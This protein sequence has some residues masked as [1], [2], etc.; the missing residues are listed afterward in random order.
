[1]ARGSGMRSAPESEARKRESSF[2]RSGVLIIE[3]GM[4]PLELDGRIFPRV[5]RAGSNW[6]SIEVQ[7]M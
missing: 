6:E 5:R 7:P 1:M 2:H 3:L 4:L